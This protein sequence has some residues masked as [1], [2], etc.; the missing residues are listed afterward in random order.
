M[1]ALVI[2]PHPDDETLGCG[3]TIAKLADNGVDVFVIAVACHSIN[4]GDGDDLIAADRETEFRDACKILGAAGSEIAMRPQAYQTL[5]EGE[6]EIVALIEKGSTYSLDSLQPDLV[7]IPADGAYHQDHRV[8]H[9]AAFAACRPR[10]FGQHLPPTVLGYYGPED[11][12]RSET[13]SVP[14]YFDIS[15]ARERKAEALRVYALQLREFPHPRSIRAVEAIDE[16]NGA[17]RGVK[18]AELF[19]PYRVDCGNLLKTGR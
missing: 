3:G 15:D 8:V 12:W 11:E 10:G 19:T 18:A 13:R 6:A 2:A 9:K 1:R 17:H 7:F 4:T 16:I 14:M 5:H